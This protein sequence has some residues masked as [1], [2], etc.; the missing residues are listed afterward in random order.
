[1]YRLAS[2]VLAAAVLWLSPPAP[3]YAQTEDLP[4]PPAGYKPAVPDVSEAALART[5]VDTRW[6]TI[7]FGFAPILDYT[8][9][10][11]DA[12]SIDQVGVQDDAFQVRSGRIMVR[13]N[14]FNTGARPWRYLVSFEYKGLDSNPEQTWNMTDVAVTIPLGAAIG[15]LTLGKVKEPFVY[16]MVGD[17]ANLPFLERL[18]NPFFASRNV[19]ARLDRTAFGRR[20]TWSLGVFNDGFTAGV[21]LAQSGT[22]VSARVT[23]LPW[24]TADGRRYLHVGTGWRHS[25]DDAG[26]VRL[27]GRP[28]SNV[29]DNYVDTGNI[30]AS[31]STTVSL[32][33]LLNVGPASVTAEYAQ[34]HV[35]SPAKGD[36]SFSGWYVAASYV[37][38][39]EARP[40]DRRVG[41]AR[42]VLPARRWG[43]VEVFARLGKVDLATPMVDGGYLT[44]WFTGVNWWASRRWR[45]SA[46][47]GRAR[48]DR[49]GTTG[50]TN[51]VLTRLQWIY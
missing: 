14:L 24:I 11:Q 50:Y 34:A 16:E 35:P 28:E 39:G 36:P 15:D 37:L 17:A 27:K 7:R 41:Y 26:S 9:L 31:H 51:Q 2:V 22:Q 44:K 42:R 13:G 48:L 30:P 33:S 23:G 1:M 47:Y 49:F 43:A 6:L 10:S 20:T 18:L 38:T 40:Y 4:P 19:G 12:A 29:T 46:G 45:V 21:P 8:S 5:A 3:A 25:G 32:E